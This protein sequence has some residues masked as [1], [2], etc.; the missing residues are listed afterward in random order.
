MTIVYESRSALETQNSRP[1]TDTEIAEIS[2]N[3][4]VITPDEVHAEAQHHPAGTAQQAT[5][6]AARAL[7]LRQLL[8]QEAERL[9]LKPELTSTGASETTPQD[10]LINQLIEHVIRK[11]LFPVTIP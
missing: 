11:L 3:G 2:V 6:A 4:H 5:S 7:V 9:G 1:S 8:L 10:S